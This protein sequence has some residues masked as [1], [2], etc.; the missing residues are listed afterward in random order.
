[1]ERYFAVVSQSAVLR[2][3]RDERGVA[4]RF[5]HQANLCGE[6]EDAFLA[7]LVRFMW[8][9]HGKDFA[10]LRVELHHPCPSPGPGPYADEFGVTPPFGHHESALVLP[11]SEVDAPL[12]G[13]CAELAQFNDKIAA[14]YLAK[15][16][17][18]DVTARV[19]AKIIE[20]LSAGDCTRRKVA[21]DL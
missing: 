2:V 15:L 3:E 6:T 14:D 1:L 8:L 18:K 20:L 16:D 10:P 19:R 4:L 11:A 13:A 21:Q 17:R 5:R 9:L 12:S 7:F